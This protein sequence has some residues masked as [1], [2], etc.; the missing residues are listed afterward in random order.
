MAAPVGVVSSALIGRR[1]Q[2]HAFEQLGRARRRDRHQAVGALDRA[3]AGRHRSAREPLDAEQIEADGGAGDVGDAVERPDLVKMDLFQRQAVDGRL[4]LG[5]A[6]KDAQGQVA[7]RAA[8]E[9][10]RCRISSICGR[11]RW[12]CSSGASTRTYV[13]A[14]PPLRTFSTSSA[15]GR[16]SEAT[17]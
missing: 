17:P 10:P 2:R 15:I 5:Q 12:L 7:L 13:A 8:S 14:K 9:S 1:R 4:G 6:A 16:P 3:A 11:W